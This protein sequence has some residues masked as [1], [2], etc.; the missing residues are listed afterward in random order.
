MNFERAHNQYLEPPDDDPVCEFC[1]ETLV[2]DINAD[3]F[4]NNRFCPAQFGE[5][6]VEHGMAEFILELKDKIE[7]LEWK[8][9]GTNK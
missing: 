3:W 4:C 5:G 7:T 2:P 8:L 9:K 1:G 6:T